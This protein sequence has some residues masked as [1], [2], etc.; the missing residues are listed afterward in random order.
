MA[1]QSATLRGAR[2]RPSARERPGKILVGTASWS[3]PGFIADWYP[4]GLP[5]KERLPY[6][7]GYFSLVE[8]NSSFYAVPQAKLVERWCEQT[9]AGFTFDVK[10]HRL[11]SRHS[12]PVK[13]LPSDLRPT[14][15]VSE[16]AVLTPKLEKA[17]AQ[18]FLDAIAPFEDAGKMGAL[19]LQLS[20]SFGPR[21]HTLNELG[22][23]LDLLADHKVAVELRNR[24]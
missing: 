4:P 10:L 6:Y 9:P 11:L 22:D 18:R 1:A 16:K 20:P 14:G 13:Q 21:K 7:A 5:A 17:L 24:S 19:L 2:K 3:D 23:L 12:T 8:L 15:G